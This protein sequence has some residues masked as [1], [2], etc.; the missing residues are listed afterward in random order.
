M[1]CSGTHIVSM[2]VAASGEVS[3]NGHQEPNTGSAGGVEALIDELLSILRGLLADQQRR[4]EL[5]RA[6]AARMTLEL[7]ANALE[8]LNA[9]EVYQRAFVKAAKLLR[10]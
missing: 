8:G 5:E 2:V 6:D 9:N 10:E 4:I 3:D 7:A 1:I